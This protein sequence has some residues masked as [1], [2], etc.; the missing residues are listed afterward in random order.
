MSAN[1]SENSLSEPTLSERIIKL[2]QEMFAFS[3]MGVTHLQTDRDVL[4]HLNKG[5]PVDEGCMYIQNILVCESGDAYEK[6]AK[7]NTQTVEDIRF[8][9]SVGSRIV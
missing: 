6:H 2:Q 9:Q 1:L 5:R 4:K 7:K 8:G 3:A